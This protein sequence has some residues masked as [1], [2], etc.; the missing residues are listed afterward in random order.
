MVKLVHKF[1]QIRWVAGISSEMMSGKQ[2]GPVELVG[3]KEIFMVD[4]GYGLDPFQYR[5]AIDGG[6][7]H[8]GADEAHP[9][10]AGA[11]GAEDMGV[12]RPTSQYVL[13]AFDTRDTP[14]AFRDDI[15]VG[16]ATQEV[17]E[18]VWLRF[19]CVAMSGNEFQGHPVG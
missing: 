15:C 8:G 18:E 13:A 16:V 19:C 10:G 11:D 9:G 3:G 5:Y 6:P 14:T 7:R 1:Q 4:V 17:P 2:A 12:A